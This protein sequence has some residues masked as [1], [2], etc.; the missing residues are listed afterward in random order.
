MKHLLKLI[1]ITF[2]LI[3]GAAPN[4]IIAIVNEQVITFDTISS[5]IKPTST[6]AQKMALVQHQIDLALQLE[7]VQKFGIQ[8][9]PSAVNVALS[10]IA[11]QNSLTPAQLQA[12]P[13]YDEIVQNI[14]QKLSL[15][16]LQK[17]ML[18]EVDATPTEAEISAALQK[19]NSNNNVFR[20]QIKIAQI[21][22]NSIDQTNDPTL[23][24]NDLIKQFL[25]KLSNKI[26]K[27]SNTF[28]SLAKLHSQDPSYRQGG[29]SKWLD[30]DRLPTIIKQQLAP[31]KLGELS[32]PFQT[33][34]GWRII[35]IIDQR[36]VDNTRLEIREKIT[37]SKQHTYFKNWVKELRKKAYIEIFE[38]KF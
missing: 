30:K 14:T 29:E 10:R 17:F 25:V 2:S 23:S 28:S 32:P 3:A 18:Q 7:A 37:R 6:K 26:N 11:I 20:E 31:L 5:Q 8:P 27:G 21:L 19:N 4:S 16:G 1:F 13:E 24:K 33:E 9:K 15:L 22:I 12:L 36:K 38:H 35:K 34:Q